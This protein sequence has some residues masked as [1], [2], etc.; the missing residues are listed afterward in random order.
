MCK[1]KILTIKI[2]TM[3][4]KGKY[5]VRCKVVINEEIMEQVSN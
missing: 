5:G 3:V 1:L 4:F 2:K